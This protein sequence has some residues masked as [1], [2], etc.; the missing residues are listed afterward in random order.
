MNEKYSIV[1]VEDPEETAWGII[2]RG[3]GSY[4]KQQ[5]GDNK[6]QRICYVLQKHG[7]EIAG[8]VIAEAYWEWLYVDLLWVGEQLRGQGFGHLLLA[9][10]EQEAMRLGAKHAYLDTF[11]FQAPEFYKQHGYEVFGELQDFPVGHTRYFF[12]KELK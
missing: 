2:G 4:N 12:T 10:A 7:Q 5:V 9:A 3:V 6:F 11:S 1:Q 8:G